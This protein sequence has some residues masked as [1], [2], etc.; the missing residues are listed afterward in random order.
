MDHALQLETA[1]RR[2]N[3]RRR[4][5]AAYIREKHNLPCTA[6]T[7]ATLASRSGGPPFYLFGR[8]P[9]YSEEGLDAW[10]KA[11]MGEPVRSTSEARR[12]R[13]PSK[14]SQPASAADKVPAQ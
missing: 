4:E 14:T 12:F 1:G 13:E 7:L 5:A 6:A 10:V 11:R 9:I 8:I 3:Y 2:R